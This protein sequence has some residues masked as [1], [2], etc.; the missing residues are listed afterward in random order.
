[1]LNFQVP[2]DSIL[3]EL[4][5]EA[6]PPL[7][8]DD[9]LESL[10][11]N[12]Y[13]ES[14][15]DSKDFAESVWETKNS[16]SDLF[17][18]EDNSSK[19]SIWERT[20]ERKENAGLSQKLFPYDS[21]PSLSRESSVEGKATATTNDLLS[22]KAE[23]TIL[24]ADALKKMKSFAMSKSSRKRGSGSLESLSKRQR[25]ESEEDAKAKA[26]YYIAQRL[27]TGSLLLF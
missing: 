1:M 25:T 20:P 7:L 8:A 12:D 19:E 4:F 10:S 15:W 23:Q 16:T 14:E 11:T 5:V 22:M 27:V 26:A 2:K 3:N 24:S 17:L 9:G 21:T 6:H 13:G 18:K